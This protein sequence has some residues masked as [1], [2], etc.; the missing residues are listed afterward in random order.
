MESR[1]NQQGESEVVPLLVK[2]MLPRIFCSSHSHTFL[3]GV[4][5]AH[6]A[7]SAA[8][9]R[10]TTKKIAAGRCQTFVQETG[11]HINQKDEMRH[12]QCDYRGLDGR[13]LRG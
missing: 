6:K 5:I 10:V 2:S 9:Y 12:P 4:D 3:C 1:E 7:V 11:C 8:G 13:R